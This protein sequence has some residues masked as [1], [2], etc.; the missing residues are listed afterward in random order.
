L[1]LICVCIGTLLASPAGAKQAQ[2][3]HPKHAAAPA[4]TT[5]SS[6]SDSTSA[7]PGS[8]STGSPGG[9]GIA[10]HQGGSKLPWIGARAGAAAAAVGTAALLHGQTHSGT[11]PQAMTSTAGGTPPTTPGGTD[12]PGGTNPPVQDPQQNP[13][14]GSG[15]SQPLAPT[16]PPPAPE[17]STLP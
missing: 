7:R 3:H 9:G 2:K 14:L 4:D 8:K 17:P 13:D 5:I 12:P 15:G 11:A 6:R 10:L 16:T 1:S